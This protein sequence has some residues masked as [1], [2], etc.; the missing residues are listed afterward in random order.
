MLRPIIGGDATQSEFV[1]TV[2]ENI[3]EDRFEKAENDS[4]NPLSKLE[5]ATLDKY[6]N[7]KK[8]LSKKN[9][10]AIRARLD[11]DQ[12]EKYLITFPNDVVDAIGKAMVENGIEISD[13][14]PVSCAKLFE[15]ILM[16][17]AADKIVEKEKGELSRII[18]TA[19]KELELPAPRNTKNILN[20]NIT[21]E[22]K[23]DGDNH[24]KAGDNES[25]NFI[26]HQTWG[27]P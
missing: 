23:T 16:E 10:R 22:S 4:D 5:P 20:Q 9:A 1:L 17:C 7:G 12:F 24:V 19:P 13:D 27:Y 8:P 11:K 18:K 3:M 14:I 25:N 6:F 15:A 2:T 21:F 26:C